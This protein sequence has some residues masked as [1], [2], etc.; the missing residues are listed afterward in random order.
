MSRAYHSDQ[1]RQAAKSTATATAG[2]V[3][4]QT[5]HLPR[6]T[7][8]G[9]PRPIALRPHQSPTRTTTATTQAPPIATRRCACYAKQ[10]RDPRGPNMRRSYKCAKRGPRKRAQ[11][12]APTRNSPETAQVHLPRKRSAQCSNRYSHLDCLQQPIPFSY[13]SLPF[14]LF[15]S[16]EYVPKLPLNIPYYTIQ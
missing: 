2:L 11:F 9:T 10:A 14:P 13:L 7:G 1:R 6:E 5:L 3:Y 12:P 4:H 16:P 15:R 8:R